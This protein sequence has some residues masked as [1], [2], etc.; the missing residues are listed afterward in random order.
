MPLVYAEW[1]LQAISDDTRPRLAAGVDAIETARIQ[2][3]LDRFGRRFLERVYTENEQRYSRGRP[4]ELAVRFAGK[5]ALSKALGTGMRG[6]SWRELEILNN[7]RGKPFVR[8]HGA[9]AARAEQLGLT[10][11]EISLTHSRDLAIAFVVATTD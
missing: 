3:T 8:L 6:V 5:E 10:A 11:F 1:S 7:K 4:E 9:A 2:A